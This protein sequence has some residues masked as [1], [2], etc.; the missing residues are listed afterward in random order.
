MAEALAEGEVHYI[1]T[2]EQNPKVEAVENFR[3]PNPGC[4]MCNT[5]SVS[6]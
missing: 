6:N 2:V 5:S 3:C 4:E 1:L